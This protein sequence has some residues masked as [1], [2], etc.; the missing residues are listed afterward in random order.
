MRFCPMWS[1]QQQEPVLHTCGEENEWGRAGDD[2]RYRTTLGSGDWLLW[3][4]GGDK[5]QTNRLP[6]FPSC[7]SVFQFL[8]V[9]M[10]WTHTAWNPWLLFIGVLGPTRRGDGYLHFIS[11]NRTL[12][13]LR[14]E[15]FWRGMNFGLVSVWK[16]NF[17]AGLTLVRKIRHPES[18]HRVWS[19]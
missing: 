13:R 4:S 5:N 9:A 8:Q 12:I 3:W 19:G 17:P 14:L 18:V 6:T 16:P 2:D 10:N 15:D 7:S 11:I 1:T